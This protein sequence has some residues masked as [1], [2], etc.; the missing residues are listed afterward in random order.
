M[1]P[2]LSTQANQF[3]QQNPN[4]FCE[5][6]FKFESGE[7]FIPYEYQANLMRALVEHRFVA[8]MFS[9]QTGKTEIDSAIADIEA[10]LHDGHNIPITAPRQRH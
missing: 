7:A 5:D 9:R 4:N 6:F 10:L 3:Y 2:G 8:G 1:I